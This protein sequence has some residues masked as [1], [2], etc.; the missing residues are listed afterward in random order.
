MNWVITK[1]QSVFSSL[2]VKTRMEKNLAS[3]PWFL[4]EIV[5]TNGAV[6]GVEVE[7]DALE[8]SREDSV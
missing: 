4:E 8:V 1:N 5:E 2:S 3:T 7:G 6:D